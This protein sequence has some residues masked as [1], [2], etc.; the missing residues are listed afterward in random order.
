MPNPVPELLLGASLALA[1]QGQAVAQHPPEADRPT[2]ALTD[3]TPIAGFETI[4]ALSE[5]WQRVEVYSVPNSTIRLPNGR[6][7]IEH[8]ARRVAG[9]KGASGAESWTTSR[10]CPALHSTLIW[11]TVLIA[12]RIEIA[13]VSPGEAEPAGRRPLTM[14][15]DGVTTMVWGRGTQPDHSLNAYV[16]M[17]SNGGLIADFGRAAT[18][19]LES[20]WTDRKPD[21]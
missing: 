17:S 15:A 13:G 10:D 21:F 12:P 3:R 4:N 5:D 7:W 18:D 6:P 8:I 20:C 9:A 14:T 1:L 19:N 2:S 16:E 11:M